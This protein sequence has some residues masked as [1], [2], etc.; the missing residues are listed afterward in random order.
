MSGQ[1]FLIRLQLET[2]CE[3]TVDE[4]EVRKWAEGVFEGCDM[5][6]VEV[7][8]VNQLEF[9]RGKISDED[10]GELEI[11]MAT[12]KNTVVVKFAT[13]ISWMGLDANGAEAFANKMLEQVK[14]IREAGHGHEFPEGN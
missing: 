2:E 13:P 10:E 11:A 6:R 12:V 9:P 4:P 7:K 5:G 14:G 8:E 1:K 3:E